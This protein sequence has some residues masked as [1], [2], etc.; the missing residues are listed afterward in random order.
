MPQIVKKQYVSRGGEWVEVSAGGLDQA[1]ADT[2]YAPIDAGVPAGVITVWMEAA[3]PAGW[4]LCNGTL[5]SRSAHSRLFDVVGEKYGAGDGAT[6]FATP[7]LGGRVPVGLDAG[8]VEFAALGQTGGEKT[9]TL[10]SNEIPPHQH[11]LQ[12]PA[13]H[14]LATVYGGGVVP[15]TFAFTPA[16]VNA[17]SGYSD[18]WKTSVDGGGGLAHNVLQPYTVVNY[19]IKT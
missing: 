11:V 8:Q 7:N 4:A 2:L 15:S 3:A 17:A 13:G 18:I 6:T 5:L 10:N 14:S 19:I 12:G 1:T 16:T 9:H